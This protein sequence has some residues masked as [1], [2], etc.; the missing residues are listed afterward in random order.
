MVGREVLLA[1][2]GRGI[3]CIA[4]SRTEPAFLPPSVRWHR[5]DLANWKSASELDEMVPAVDAVIHLGAFVGTAADGAAPRQAML[6][7][8][9]RGTLCVAEWALEKRVPLVFVSSASVYAN[10]GERAIPESAPRTLDGIAGFYGLSKCL[11]EDVLGHLAAEGLAACILRPS[12]IYGYGLPGTKMVMRFLSQ[13]AAGDTIELSP[14][15]D[16]K[17]DLL[18]AADVARAILDAVS[19]GARGV[20]NISSGAPVSVRAIAQACVDVTGRGQV[21]VA[22]DAAKDEPRVRFALDSAAARRAFGFAPS[23]SLEAGLARTFADL[24]AAGRHG[25]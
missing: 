3:G 24:S 4:S 9:V 16:D 25:V 12:S 13:A 10:P 18:H 15:V 19:T 17:V 6:D 14:P 22:A 1:L 8:N 11:A 7:V 20:Y 2:A 23:L 21:V 5:W